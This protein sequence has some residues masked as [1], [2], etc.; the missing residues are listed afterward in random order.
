MS[1]QNY[2]R[3][4]LSSDE[5]ELS[6]SKDV[7]ETPNVSAADDVAETPE[8]PVFNFSS[9]GATTAV[10]NKRLVKRLIM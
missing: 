4:L 10:L 8:S 2:V 9:G 3:H 1:Q 7:G 5:E 6:V